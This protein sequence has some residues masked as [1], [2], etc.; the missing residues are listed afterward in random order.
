[1]VLLKSDH[2]RM[3][4]SYLDNIYDGNGRE[5]REGGGGGG[6]VSVRPLILLSLRSC[7]DT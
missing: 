3:G 6:Y 7:E 4:F 1:M 5:K 2:K